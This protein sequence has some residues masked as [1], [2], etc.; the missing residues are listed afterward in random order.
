MME[1]PAEHPGE[2]QERGDENGDQRQEYAC[3]EEPIF[4]GLFARVFDVANEESIVAA[5]GLPG[6]VEGVAEE[7][8]RSDEDVDG[9]VDEHAGEGDV[10]NSADPGGEDEDAG[11]E[12][13][14]DVSE[15]GDEADD[16]VEAEANLRARD[17]EAVV[18]EMS[19]EI[20]ILIAEKAPT[21]AEAG[22]GRMPGAGRIGGVVRREDFGL[23]GRGH[24]LR[25]D[26]CKSWVRVV[27]CYGCRDYGMG[28]SSGAWSAF[29][30]CGWYN[31]ESHGGYSSVA[32]R[33]S[34]DPDVVGS[35][36]TSRPNLAITYGTF[37]TV[38]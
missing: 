12:S 33:R 27:L 22:L 19:E 32:E 2:N 1:E 17:T 24:L 14:E 4:P 26:Y 38:L 10:G 20:E 28:L 16:A 36:P 13:G 15:C 31:Q 11:G 37:V 7:G 25:L 5:I 6:D 3:E 9:K 21:G 29:G 18:E 8:D 35:T 30:G 34:V 23:P